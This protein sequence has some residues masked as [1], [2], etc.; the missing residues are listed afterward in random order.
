MRRVVWIKI[1]V[2]G[3]FVLCHI[4]GQPYLQLWKSTNLQGVAEANNRGSACLRLVSQIMNA[5][6]GSFFRMLQHI[7]RYFLLR[8]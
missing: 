8:L 4:K 3:A 7:S 2:G 6:D 1:I 5:D